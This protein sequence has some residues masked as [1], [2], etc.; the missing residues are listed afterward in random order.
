MQLNFAHENFTIKYQ[1][2]QQGLLVY[3]AFMWWF[4]AKASYYTSYKTILPS[5][6]AQTLKTLNYAF[7]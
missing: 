2:L 4:L 3:D 7:N 1:I 5:F 6:S